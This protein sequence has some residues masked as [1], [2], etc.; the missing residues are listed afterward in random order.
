MT[1]LQLTTTSGGSVQLILDNG[2]AHV[3]GTGMSNSQQVSLPVDTWVYVGLSWRRSDGR[4]LLRVRYAADDVV[5]TSTAGFSSGS[6]VTVR[7]VTLCSNFIA[8]RST[9]HVTIAY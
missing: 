8:Y 3:A 6:D 9:S 7:C 5:S 4:V 2:R 1:L